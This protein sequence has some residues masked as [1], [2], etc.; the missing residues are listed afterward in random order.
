M[1]DIQFID[2]ILKRKIKSS[3]VKNFW[4][5]ED[6]KNRNI[7]KLLDYNNGTLLFQRFFL[8]YNN[9]DK[10]ENLQIGKSQKVNTKQLCKGQKISCKEV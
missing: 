2:C 5:F 3:E 9:Y 7:I 10:E 4:I 1:M 8:D 6:Y